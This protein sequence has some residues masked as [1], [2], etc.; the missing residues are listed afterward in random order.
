MNS[1]DKWIYIIVTML[2]GI[3]LVFSYSLPIYLETIHNWG[4]FYFFKKFLIYSVIGIVIMFVLSQLN[5]DKVLG[6]LGFGLLFISMILIVLMPNILSPY[7]PVIKGAR[8]WIRIAFFTISPTEFLKIGMIYFFAWGFSRKLSNHNFKNLKEEIKALIPYIIVIGFTSFYIIIYQSDLGQTMLIFILFIVMLLFTG[9][10]YEVF[11]IL[12]VSAIGVFIIGLMNGGYRIERIKSSLYNIYLLMPDFIQN[13]FGIEVSTQNIS[14][15]IR[16]SINAI[17]NGGLFGKGI[18]DGEFKMGFL[19]D[20]HTD[21][22]LAGIAEEIGFFGVL[23]V[24]MLITALIWRIF[25]I[26]NRIEPKSCIDVIHKLFAIG[27]GLLIGF[28]TIL[29]AMGI[30]GLF[31]LKGLPVPF[32]SYGGSALISFSIAVGMVLMLSKKAKL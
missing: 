22:V 13:F 19:S 31:P 9:V 10:G 28:E 1:A 29:N 27:V 2:M 26:A 16:Q 21:F 18:G 20:V 14:Y 7:C 30:I 23:L 32:V 11:A 12:I 15:Q 6:K 25:K 3:G 4:E 8:R 24:M 17:Y 5:P